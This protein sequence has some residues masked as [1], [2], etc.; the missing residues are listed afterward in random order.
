METNHCYII[1]LS[2][3]ENGEMKEHKCFYIDED[4]YNFYLSSHEYVMD[5]VQ[6]LNEE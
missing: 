4:D 1:S 5:L 6:T 3:L 2:H